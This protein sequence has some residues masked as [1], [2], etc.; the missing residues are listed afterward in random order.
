MTL[1]E[2]ELPIDEPG[3]FKYAT[4]W[5]DTDLDEEEPRVS[6]FGRAIRAE[7]EPVALNDPFFVS[8][9]LLRSINSRCLHFSRV[10]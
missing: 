3:E 9:P 7:E 1:Y 4:D 2:D 8:S 6:F 5:D 10:I